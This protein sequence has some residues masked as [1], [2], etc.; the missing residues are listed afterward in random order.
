MAAA[1]SAANVE[2]P[3]RL[4]SADTALAGSRVT[5]NAMPS[6]SPRT[7]PVSS[8]ADSSATSAARPAAVT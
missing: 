6:F 3:N 5:E 2:I 8:P 7:T 1:V 4:M